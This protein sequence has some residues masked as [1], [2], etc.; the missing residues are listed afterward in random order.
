M[1]AFHPNQT[2]EERRRLLLPSRKVPGM[3]VGGDAFDSR[4]ELTK[5]GRP[6]GRPFPRSVRVSDPKYVAVNHQMVVR[7]LEAG[8]VDDRA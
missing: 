2:L 4:S 1:A 6:G 3:S 7:R 8:D 5:K